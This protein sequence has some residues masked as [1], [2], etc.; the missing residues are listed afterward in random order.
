MSIG[1][2]QIAIVVALVVL[3]FGRGKISELMG[4]VAKGIKSFKKGMSDEN[5][6]NK[7]ISKD[8]NNKSES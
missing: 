1:F 5:S 2:W 4:D 6:E 7:S 8:D 3:L